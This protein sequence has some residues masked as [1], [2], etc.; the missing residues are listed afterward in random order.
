MT[1]SP[2]SW[3]ASHRTATALLFAIFVAIYLHPFAGNELVYLPAAYRFWHPA[4]LAGDWSFAPRGGEHFLFNAVVGGLMTIL[5]M[6]AVG[7]IGRLLTWLFLADGLLRLARRFGLPPLAG[8]L[9]VLAWLTCGQT[10]VGS[11][12]MLPTFEAKTVAYVFL[13]QALVRVLDDDLT[14][15][16][17]MT[18]LCFS[19][20]PSVGLQGGFGIFVVV[21]LRGDLRATLR[22]AAIGFVLA[23]PGV[24]PVVPLLLDGAGNGADQW[25]FLTLVSMPGHLNPFVPGTRDRVALAGGLLAFT[26][27]LLRSRGGDVLLRSLFRFEAGLALIFAAGLAAR[28]LQMW[29]LL[30]FFP[31]RVFPLFALLFFFLGLFAAFRHWRVTR[32][33]VGLAGLALLLLLWLPNPVTK[34]VHMVTYCRTSNE[35]G[36]CQAWGHEP[37]DLGAAMLWIRDHTPAGT[38]ALLPPWRKDAFWLARRGTVAS[39]HYVPYGREAEWRRRLESM[40]GRFNDTDR[41]QA[42]PARMERSWN[43]LAEENVRTLARRYGATFLISAAEYGLPVVHHEGK[44]SVYKLGER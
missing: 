1:E 38:V 39:W 29:D 2:M 36:Y 28:A 43:N 19:I 44:W 31:F 3:T 30:K 16:A 42:N 32:P 41:N 26:W 34:F 23:L 9:A 18:G 22:F 33:P 11:E 20:H 21:L 8:S 17:V 15:S 12:W 7:W 40:L 35:G 37:D 6:E 5:P 24:L 13:L 14:I 25:R 27:L 10:V 4:F